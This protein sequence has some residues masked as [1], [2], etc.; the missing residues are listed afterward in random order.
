MELSA[1]QQERYARHLLLDDFGGAGQERLLAAAVRVQGSSDAARW[2][3][4]YLAASGVGTLD[5]EVQGWGPELLAAG[6]SLRLAPAAGCLVC[7]PEEGAS[8]AA[9]AMHGALAAADAIRR[10]LGT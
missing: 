9:G 1:A 10:L 8:P 5:V 4:L 3:A 6:P 2:A 7:R